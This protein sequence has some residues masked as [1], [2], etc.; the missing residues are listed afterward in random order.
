M[1][2]IRHVEARI[3]EAAKTFHFPAE[4]I[5][6]AGVLASSIG[7]TA[8][9]YVITSEFPGSVHDDQWTD[10]FIGDLSC[11]GLGRRSY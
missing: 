1:R 3:P 10:W 5:Y 7:A 4:F 8:G 11:T 6:V 9:T 2:L